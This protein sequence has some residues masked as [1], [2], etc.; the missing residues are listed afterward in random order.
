MNYTFFELLSLAKAKLP[1]ETNPV[2]RMRKAQLVSSLE[3]L[4]QKQ[5][6]L[7]ALREAAKLTRPHIDDW[8][9]MHLNR[10]ISHLI[11]RVDDQQQV[12]DH[13]LTVPVTYQPFEVLPDDDHMGQAKQYELEDNE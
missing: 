8:E 9:V 10:V 7:K 11:G 6:A 5:E 2:L 4:K 13:A 1:E 3:N 12:I